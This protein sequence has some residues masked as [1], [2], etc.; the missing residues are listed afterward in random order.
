MAKNSIGILG[1]TFNPIHNKHLELARLAYEQFDLAKVLVIP[2]GISYL[3]EGT[4]VLP[5]KVRYDMCIEACRDDSR[6]EVSDIEIRREGST[7][8]CDTLRELITL[9]PENTYYF[10]VGTDSFFAMDSWHEPGYIFKSCIIVVA[11]RGSDTA[12]DISYQMKVYEGRYNAA[13]RILH[14]QPEETSSTE[15]RNMI[16]EGKDVSRLLPAK[17]VK[18]ID[19]NGLY[20]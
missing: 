12:E 18:Y 10:I 14:L 11:A 7:Y 20:R 19:E 6:L 13:I 9:A 15:I 16:R 17:L 4:G 5:G 3:K 8:T 2:S 1:G